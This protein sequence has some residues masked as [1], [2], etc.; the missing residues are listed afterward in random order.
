MHSYIFLNKTLHIRKIEK[1][2]ILYWKRF[3]GSKSWNP[4]SIIAIILLKLHYKYC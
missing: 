1:H 4:V 2:I 3:C